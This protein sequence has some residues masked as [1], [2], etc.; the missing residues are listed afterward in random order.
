MSFPCF[1]SH[2]DDDDDDNENYRCYMKYFSTTKVQFLY[3]GEI[4]T[5]YYMCWVDVQLLWKQASRVEVLG[6]MAA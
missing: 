1:L 4:S 3:R 5:V 2:D 6:C